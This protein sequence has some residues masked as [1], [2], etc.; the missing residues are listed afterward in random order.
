[1]PITSPARPVAAEELVRVPGHC[2]LIQ[3]ALHLLSPSGGQHCLC[4]LR[5]SG[6]LFAY[7]DANGLGECFSSECGFLLERDPD[8]VLAPDLASSARIGC[9]TPCR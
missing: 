2:E 8:T 7:V 1:M 5:L 4:T 6:H 9:R 3:G